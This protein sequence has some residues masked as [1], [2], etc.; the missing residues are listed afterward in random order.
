MKL[1]GVDFRVI[2]VPVLFGA[3][4]AIAGCQKPAVESDAGS[5]TGPAAGATED[6][7]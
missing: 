5:T 4:L 6:E 3:L 1:F 7:T 2:V